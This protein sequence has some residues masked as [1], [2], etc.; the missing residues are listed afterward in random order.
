VRFVK[1]IIILISIFS[2]D[3]LIQTNKQD[4][5]KSSNVSRICDLNIESILEQYTSENSNINSWGP[6][7]IVKI[8]FSHLEKLKGDIKEVRLRRF[9]YERRFD[10]DHWDLKIDQTTVF[11][12]NKNPIKISRDDGYIKD[13]SYDSI[14]NS[15][16]VLSLEIDEVKNNNFPSYNLKSST[17]TKNNNEIIFV[18][19]KDFMLSGRS[20]KY[21]Y[22]LSDE[23]KQ[24]V[25]RI[26]NKDLSRPITVD[27]TKIYEDSLGR[28]SKKIVYATYVRDYGK[29]NNYDQDSI[30]FKY[31]RSDRGKTI[32]RY[33]ANGRLSGETR[34]YFS[35]K[36]NL[37]SINNK[38][39][40]GSIGI[41]SP[42]LSASEILFNFD[43][44]CRVSKVTSVTREGEY[45]KL[46]FNEHSDLD[47]RVSY[48][49][50]DKNNSS[51]LRYDEKY[52]QLF[53]EDAD[54]M[55]LSEYNWH[56]Y[57]NYKY[58]SIGNWTQR[59]L[60]TN[61]EGYPGTV[62]LKEKRKIVYN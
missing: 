29:R 16:S 8:S 20:T 52:K 46:E 26:L 40:G 2:C 11:N 21:S 36:S 32:K 50:P 51:K 60:I 9:Q 13:I 17:K 14:L 39:Y 41:E 38:I 10:E 45:L 49:I 24:G 42:K 28:V 19:K 18:T 27:K 59:R 35:R 34:I 56:K 37:L 5:S 30:V 55:K 58:D 3:K 44:N 22:L 23:Y 54:L 53:Y 7:P 48:K 43:S 12:Q 6:E 15:I 61:I 4:I 33:F 62:M 57:D 1:F 25:K 31:Y 47:G